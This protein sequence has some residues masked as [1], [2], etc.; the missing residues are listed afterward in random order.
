MV[1]R[2]AMSA[3][4]PRAAQRRRPVLHGGTPAWADGS[5]IR[6]APFARCCVGAAARVAARVAG[7]FGIFGTAVPRAFAASVA[8]LDTVNHASPL[9][10]SVVAGSAAPSLGAGAVLQTLV[11]LALVIGAVFGCAWLARRFGFQ[12]ARGGN[13][14]LKVVASV[15]VGGKER[16]TIV[17]IGDTSLVLGV[18]PGNVRLLHALSA[19]AA[20]PAGGAHPANRAG[21]AIG[22]VAAGGAAERTLDA[23]GM[24]SL[25]ATSCVESADADGGAASAGGV[26]SP[27][28]ASPH[29]PTLAGASAQRFRDA[30]LE[31]AAKRFRM[32]GESR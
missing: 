19:S 17:A 4:A 3:V 7:I 29:R 31:V 28:S 30:L 11:A 15:A 1:A 18:A 6:R 16:V 8:S 27:A 26:V 32:G 20:S 14:A 23:A 13:V 12:P 21:A 10:S 5:R 9:A 24:S 22:G 2:A 25:G